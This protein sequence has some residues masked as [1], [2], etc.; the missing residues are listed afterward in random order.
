MAL[1]DFSGLI[2]GLFTDNDFP[3]EQSSLTYVYSGDDK[4]E[5]MKF[6]R[7]KNLCSQPKF[8]GV[9]GFLKIH[10]EKKFW[11]D[12]R[13]LRF[14]LAV[15]SLNTRLMEQIIP[16]LKEFERNFTSNYTGITRKKY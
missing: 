13:W 12:R 16:G 7:A 1:A 11:N 5:R 9:G 8:C 14:P 6:I 3:P 10:L 2:S 4:Y 15:I